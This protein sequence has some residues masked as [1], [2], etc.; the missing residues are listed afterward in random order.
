MVSNERNGV[1]ADEVAKAK[2]LRKEEGMVVVA[3]VEENVRLLPIVR[4]PVM[5]A[6]VEA[7][8]VEESPSVVPVSPPVKVP[9]VKGR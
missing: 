3:E 2:A 6:V 4:R 9:P 1:L 5:W 7:L 8:R